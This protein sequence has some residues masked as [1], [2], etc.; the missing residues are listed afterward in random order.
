MTDFSRK[1]RVQLIKERKFSGCT[2]AGFSSLWGSLGTF[3]TCR[4]LDAQ[5]LSLFLL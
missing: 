5:L 2:L 4:R 1:A 3:G